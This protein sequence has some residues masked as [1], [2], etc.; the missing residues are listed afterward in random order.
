[1]KHL[2]TCLAL[3]VLVSLTGCE[4]EVDEGHA[5]TAVEEPSTTHA[6]NFEGTEEDRVAL[7]EAITKQRQAIEARKE[8]LSR[9]ELSTESMREQIK[10]KWSKLDYY[11]DGGEVLRIKTYPYEGVSTRTEEFYFQEGELIYAIIED[12]GVESTEAEEQE[13]KVYYYWKGTFIE[14]RNN[15]GEEEEGIRNSDEERLESEAME[16]LD[17]YQQHFGNFN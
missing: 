9:N 15:S 3:L 8:E 6:D 12:N 14:E 17:L 7:I 13:G 1:M 2:L 11:A 10:Q 4:S 16:Y 5:A